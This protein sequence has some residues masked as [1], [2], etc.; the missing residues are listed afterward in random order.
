[1]IKEVTEITC[2]ACGRSLGSV[3]RSQGELHLIPAPERPTTAAVVQKP[4][5]RLLCGRCGGRAFLGPW[6]RVVSYAA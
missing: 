6:E 5:G 3:D 4:S 1:M 2:L